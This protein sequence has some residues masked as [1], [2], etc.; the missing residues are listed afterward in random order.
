MCRCAY[1]FVTQQLNIYDSFH[2]KCYNPKTHK[3]QKLKFLV[4]N[5]NEDKISIWIC[6]A[7]YREIWVSRCGEFWVHS[8]FSGNC[9]IYMSSFPWMIGSC[10]TLFNVCSLDERAVSITC[11][12]GKIGTKIKTLGSCL[13]LLAN[14]S[15]K[16]RNVN[17]CPTAATNHSWKR[18]HVH[19]CSILGSCLALIYTTQFYKKHL[20]HN[21]TELSE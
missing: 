19:V 2:W 9:H 11:P 6:T 18:R 12:T 4:T 14:Y 5:S 21:C 20:I 8:N 17:V 13:T 10:L 1:M 7:R 3:I 16:R 15:W